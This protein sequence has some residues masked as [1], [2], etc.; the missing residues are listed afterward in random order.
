MNICKEEYK[1]KLHTAITIGKFDGIHLGHGE[2]LVELKKQKDRGMSTLLFTFSKSPQVYLNQTKETLIFT[3]EE[4]IE[5]FRQLGWIDS[6][7]EVPVT[8][9][10]LDLEPEAFVK[11]YLVDKFKVQ[12][13]IVGE[14]FR[15]GHHKKG[16]VLLLKELGE[17]YGYT[18]TS[19]KKKKKQNFKVSSTDIRRILTQGEMKKANEIL[20]HP[21]Y[22]MGRVLH[23]RE[24]ARELG[25]PTANVEY[26]KDKIQIPFGV[27]VTKI[28]V[29]GKIFNGITNVGS[30]PTV[31]EDKKVLVES[32]LFDF[33][34]ELYE[35]QIKICFYEFLRKELKF[36]TIEHLKE[37]MQRDVE[38]AKRI[39]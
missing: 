10:F 18:L 39:C 16:D 36:E 30:K 25:F 8:K 17:V 32:Y 5:F 20:G 26:P 29:E 33:E 35:K 27:Y 34:G 12:N 9:E 13:I 3:K 19:I 6:Y 15:F 38:K 24:L 23:G 4:K 31:T 28:E 22:L 2:L 7:Y 37:Q 14:D 11:K 21:F 1:S